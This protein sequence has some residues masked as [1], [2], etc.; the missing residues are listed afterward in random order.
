MHRVVAEHVVAL[1][2]DG[3][4]REGTLRLGLGVEVV[5]GVV[6]GAGTAVVGRG[7]LWVVGVVGVIWIVVVAHP[8]LVVVAG[9]AVKPVDR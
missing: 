4:E 7:E 5:E 2:V 9:R 3:G 1:R 6:V 8:R